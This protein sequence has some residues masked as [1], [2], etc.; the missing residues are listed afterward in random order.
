MMDK[1]CINSII[2]FIKQSNKFDLINIRPMMIKSDGTFKTNMN[3]C[4]IMFNKSSLSEALFAG[5]FLFTIFDGYLEN[6]YSLEKG[7]SFIKHYNGLPENTD[8]EKISKNCYRIMKIIRNGIQHSISNVTYS[9]SDD[10]NINYHYRRTSYKLNISKEGVKCLYTLIMNIIQE[11]IMGIDKKYMT[12]G[13]YIGIMNTLHNN[14]INEIKVISDD[15][16]GD[17]LCISDELFLRK[18]VRYP[19]NNPNIVHEDDQSITFLHIENNPTDDEKS[20]EYVYSTDYKYKDFLL[21]QEIGKITKGNGKSFL[22]R[23]K[24]ATIRFY[25][26]DLECK[27]KMS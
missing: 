20:N 22:E 9:D 1:E 14:M 18:F 12:Q 23:N 6:K 10:Y 16:E 8:I 4:E 17:L 24:S 25:K 5:S 11:K 13:H 2:K 15:I 26:Y 3:F 21:P 7:A 19:V 27:W